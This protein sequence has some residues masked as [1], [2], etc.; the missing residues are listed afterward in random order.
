MFTIL[1]KRVAPPDCS[2]GVCNPVS[3]TILNFT[4][5]K[6]NWE[7]GHVIGIHIDC[8][9]NDPRAKLVFKR[10]V[11]SQRP[12]PTGFFIPSLRIWKKA[13]LPFPPLPEICSCL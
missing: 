7:K 9:W 12:H 3:F 2:W 5:P 10:V 1:Q 8:L 13:L 11:V 6:W 4:D